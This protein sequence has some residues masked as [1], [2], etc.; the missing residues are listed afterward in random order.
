MRVPIITQPHFHFDTVEMAGRKNVKR[1]KMHELWQKKIDEH[2]EVKRNDTKRI[3]NGLKHFNYIK[4]IE[5][6]NAYDYLKKSVEYRM[7]R[8]NTSLGRNLDVYV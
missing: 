8:Y 7:Y 6:I 4:D 2:Y 1:A 5:E 3:E